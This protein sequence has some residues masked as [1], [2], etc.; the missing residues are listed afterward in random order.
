MGSEANRTSTPWSSSGRE[1]LDDELPVGWPGQGRELLSE[2]LAGGGLAARVHDLERRMAHA[3]PQELAS[4]VS[5][6]ADDAD[7]H[8]HGD[9]LLASTH[10]NGSPAARQSGSR[11]TGPAPGELPGRVRRPLTTRG[12]VMQIG[13]CLPH[14]GRPLETGRLLQVA[15]RADARGLDSLWVTDH[16]IVPKDVYIAYREEMLDPL[17]VLAWLAGVTER[18]ALGTSVIILPYRSPLPVA[19]LLAS[20]DVLSGGRLI[21]GAGVGWMEGEFAA[22]GV[23]FTE[24]GSRTDEALELFRK[25]WTERE[26]EIET[27]RHRLRGLVASPMPLQRPRP[28]IWIGG[29]SEGAYRRVARHGDGWHSTA[30]TPEAFRAGRRRRAALTGP[31]P[32][33]RARPCSRSGSP[34]GSTGSIGRGRTWA[35]CAAATRSTAPPGRSSRRFAA[36]P[37]SA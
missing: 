3:E 13:L 20:V 34:S 26:P 23:P 1:R 4:A 5:A 25:V 19:K 8:T 37:R 7:P 9:P 11:Y 17:A 32:G 22:L 31:R 28:P 16:V 36:T 30:A 18:I 6:H 27:R 10:G 2:P 14:F 35:T 33:A 24:R 15:Q 21:F 12:H 29:A